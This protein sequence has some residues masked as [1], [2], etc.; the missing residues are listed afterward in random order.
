LEFELR[1]L[2][3]IAEELENYGWKMTLS[4]VIKHMKELEKAG[5]VRHESGIF[6]KKPDARKTIYSLEGKER[7]AKL[8]KI[9][10]NDVLKPLQ[11]GMAF[12]KTAKLA[13]EVQRMSHRLNQRDRNRLEALLGKCESEGIYKHLAEDEKKKLRLWR[14]MMSII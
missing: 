1:S 6:A 14:M 8:L 11:A 12:N 4:G 7:I 10:E 3:E 5:L 2:S 13:R 9:L